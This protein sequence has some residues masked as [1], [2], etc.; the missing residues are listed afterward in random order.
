MDCPTSQKRM[1][2]DKHYQMVVVVGD[3][4]LL[5]E[6][7]TAIFVDSFNLEVFQS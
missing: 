2:R 7:E 4:V 3:Q 5:G 1:K 6:M